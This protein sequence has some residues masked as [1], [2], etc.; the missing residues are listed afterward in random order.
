MALVF[1]N[2]LLRGNRSTKYTADS[3][4]AFRSPNMEPLAKL[5]VSIQGKWLQT[6]L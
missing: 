6:V 3:L 2:I 5:G 4:D 1:D